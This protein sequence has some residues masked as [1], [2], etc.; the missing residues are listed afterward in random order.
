VG[1][2]SDY[3][4]QIREAYRHCEALLERVQTPFLNAARE[5]DDP[6]RRDAFHAA[7]ISL[8]LWAPRALPQPMGDAPSLEASRRALRAWSDAARLCHQ[9]RPDPG[10]P[11]QVALADA[12]ARFGLPMT[13][14]LRMQQGLIELVENRP[15]TDLPSLLARARLLSAT[16]SWIFLRIVLAAPGA[17]R[18]RIPAEIDVEELSHDPGIFVFIVRRMIDVFHDLDTMVGV[19]RSGLP[20]DLLAR[21]GLN[22]QKLAEIRGL[23]RAPRGFAELMNDLSLVAWRFYDSGLAKLTQSAAS[24]QP[25]TLHQLDLM[26]DGYKQALRAAQQMQFAPVALEAQASTRR[27]LSRADTVRS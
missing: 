22:P 27:G 12:M 14:W 19:P 21:H 9:G 7:Y 2:K 16:Q 25:E 13:P 1:S 8:R 15:L 11:D 18:Y 4:P 5:I 26:L 10:A 3:A 6:V 17:R 20:E 23:A 24:L